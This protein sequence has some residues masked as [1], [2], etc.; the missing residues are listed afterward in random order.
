MPRPERPPHPGDEPDF[1]RENREARLAAL[2]AVDRDPSRDPAWPWPEV[3]NAVGPLTPGILITLGGYS[4]N[5][6]TGVLLNLAS[7]LLGARIPWVYFGLELADYLLVQ[8][9]AALRLNL[10]RHRVIEGTLTTAERDAVRAEISGYATHTELMHFVPDPDLSANDA[11]TRI[12]TLLAHQRPRV[13]IIDHLHQLNYDEQDNRRLAVSAAIRALKA[14]AIETGV[15]V[16]VA[17]Q[18]RKGTDPL[19]LWRTPSTADLLETAS[20]EHVSDVVLF[21]HRQIAPSCTE[22]ARAFAKGDPAVTPQ[23]FAQPRRL[24]LSLAKHRF[25]RP[26]GTTVPLTLHTPTDRLTSA[27]PAWASASTMDAL[28]APFRPG[29]AYEPDP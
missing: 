17:A 25:G 14:I 2:A 21:T 15:T 4:G 27:D 1:E 19:Y 26:I 13:V 3:T 23:H 7:H 8:L 12:R 16:I 9:L 5:G 18:L 20:I 6:K 22:Q 29:D 11:V 24:A 10:P 28:T